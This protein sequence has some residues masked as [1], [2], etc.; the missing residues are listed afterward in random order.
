MENCGSVTQVLHRDVI[1]WR[2]EMQNS[3]KN[4]S[5]AARRLTIIG[6]RK[7]LE[8]SR[9]FQ[10]VEA[11]LPCRIARQ[12]RPRSVLYGVVKWSGNSSSISRITLFP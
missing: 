3:E 5:T 9:L 7:F 6:G 11:F 1:E 12:N 8:V 2:S 4:S 10:M